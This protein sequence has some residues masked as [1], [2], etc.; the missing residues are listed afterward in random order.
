[1]VLDSIK[2][3]IHNYKQFITHNPLLASEIESALRWVSYLA[4][5]KLT[6]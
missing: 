2:N 6:S 1:L 4:T 5:G 3:S